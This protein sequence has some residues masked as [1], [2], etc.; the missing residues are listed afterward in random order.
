MFS[1]IDNGKACRQNAA[2]R[3]PG[4]SGDPPGAGDRTVP[5]PGASRSFFLFG[6]LLSV[7][8]T[9]IL[10]LFLI[11]TMSDARA[12]DNI[13]RQG[14][15]VVTGFSGIRP[16]DAPLP[17][18]AS[19]LD[20][21]FINTE[22]T[23]AQI[24]SLA[25]PGAV[26]SG[27]LISAP[28]VLQVKANEVGQVFATVLDDGMGADVPNIYLGQTAAYGLYIV[29]PDD[30]ADG[31]AERTKT[32][33]PDA[34]WM[35]GQFGMATGGGPGSIYKID[36]ATGELSLF[37][38]IPGN[39]G[40]GIG[41]IVFDA[42]NSQFFASDLDTGLIYRLNSTGGV[43]DSFDHGVDG[44]PVRGLAAVSDDGTT[45]DIE[46]PAFD[47]EDPDTWA[48][49]QEERRVHGLAVHNGRLYYAV[50]GQVWS[51][52]VTEDGFAADARWELDADALEGNGPISDMLFDGQGRIYLAER[53]EQRGSYDYSVFAEAEN[54][55]VVRYRLEDPDDPL[56]ESIWVLE[57][58]EYAVGMP[59]DHRQAEGGIALGYSYDETGMMRFG[60]CG[61]MLWSSGHRLRRSVQAEEDAG[62]ADIHGLQG[63]DV[64]LV[65]PDNAPPD[66]SY[67]T[68][69][70][71]FFGDAANSGHMGD[72][73]IWQPCEGEPDFASVP[74][75][76]ELPP[77]IL[78]PGEIPPELPPEFPPGGDF[79]NNLALDKQALPKFCFP[80]AGG[81]LCQYHV[82]VTNTGPDFYFGPVLVEDWLPANPA[83]SA[84]GFAPTPPWSCWN[85][86]ASAYKCFRPGVFLAPG[87][88]IGLDV[89]AWVPESYG[90]CNLRNAA[91]I[92]WAPG[93]TPWNTDPFD[94]FD[95]ANA[96]I[97][98][99]ECEDP[100]EET[101]LEI[102]KSTFETC[103]I[104]GGL[105]NCAYYVS[106][107]NQGPGSYNGNIVVND[108]IPAGTNA[109]FFGAGWAC[110][111]ASPNYTCTFAGANL[112]APGD[113]E[114]FWV[115]VTLPPAQARAMDCRVPNT[116]N[117]TQAPGG[118]PMNTDPTN[119]TA[120][121]DGMVPEE[122]C[123]DE[124]EKTD[125]RI[126]KR[127]YSCY[128][129]DDGLRCY[130]R[131]YVLNM[132]PGAYEGDIKIVDTVP[133]GTTA[134]L[135]GPGWFCGGA[136]P[137]Y[138][139]IYPDAN[140]PNVWDNVFLNVRVDFTREQA[141][142]MDCRIPNTVKITEAAG[143]TPQNLNPA[144]DTDG[145]VGLVPVELCKRPAETNLRIEKK[146]NPTFCSEGQNG[147]WCRYAIRVI[148]EGPGV[149]NGPLEVEEA[150]PAEPVSAIWN[151]PWNCAGI[152]GGGG[153][154]C[155]HP[156]TV[157]PVSASRILFLSVLFSEEDVKAKDCALPNVAKIKV[158]PGG[159]QK[160]TNP[161]DDIAG[162]SA[163]VPARI[164][165][166]DETNLL[167]RKA[168]AQPECNPMGDGK[169]RCPYNVIVRNV[170]Q[171]VY[172]GEI[173]VKDSLPDAAAGATMQ[174]PAPWICVGASPSIL[175]KHP[176]TQLDPGQQVVM[177][178]NVLI[179]PADYDE[180]SLTNK[181]RIV[182]AAGGTTQ[183]QNAG[184]DEGSASLDFPPMIVGDQAFCH[185]PV[186]ATEPECPPGFEWNGERCARPGGLKPPPP[187]Q[188]PVRDCPA[189]YTGTYPDC[190]PR[191]K[192]DPQPETCPRGY[193][194]TPPNCRRIVRP[195]PKPECSGG[196]VYRNG[197]C[198]CRRPLQWNGRRC[199]RPQPQCSGGRV[200]RNGE[201][202]CRRPLQW[203]GR[204]CVRP[205][206]QCSGG[207]VLRRGEC[208]CPGRLRWN[209][210]RCVRP[211]P[212]CSGGRVFR[213][214]ECVCPRRLQWNGQRCVRPRP[215][216]SGGRV[217][218]NGECVCPRGS[219][220]NGQRCTKRQIRRPER[221]NPQPRVN[222]DVLRRNIPQILRNQ[223]NRN[224]QLR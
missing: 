64:S 221:S 187:P 197:R 110:G 177:P 147:W 98:S 2:F 107:V 10:I 120:T 71:G 80:W 195:D 12:Q 19:P 189:G 46:N 57:A 188:P 68:D 94:D 13:L 192:P 34:Q 202:V 16:A 129:V 131:I 69:Y 216:C 148:N 38:S 171:G 74:P 93:G 143:G 9:F 27:Q 211:R 28:P 84:M 112:P 61:G 134:S 160:N 86:G 196:R 163:K 105:V 66:Q 181:A 168:G 70:D 7:F 205:R 56:T 85:T 55:K 119:D 183:N 26:P 213:R 75:Y 48:F 82:R 4:C 73:E 54:S 90:K 144:N 145:A 14:D 52:G 23:S 175:C 122:L 219:R 224:D 91:F 53:G 123:T 15:A 142:Q 172:D 182:E 63:N 40:A 29:L 118:S 100:V 124:P 222:P 140:L 30:D 95:T 116:A 41:D 173:T 185:T 5:P 106:V 164:C 32:G 126:H 31:W 151:L 104:S 24:L 180:C 215:Q 158:A 190:T 87:G 198:V 174:V 89:Y 96:L 137:N 217:Y 193:T 33:A 154:I 141:R 11:A 17:E 72:V 153:A 97:P 115:K 199:V 58:E 109:S 59:P 51:I 127:A 102:F 37:A 22:G 204:R 76:G 139:C 36:G 186:P 60:A 176:S 133:A 156:N 136:S 138:T 223:Q 203:N 155:K 83:G 165:E 162:D 209:G 207:R 25:V 35:A 49:T 113:S 50:A 6:S 166:K 210:Q 200:F 167:L 42:A 88:S 65:R 130:Y 214:G 77:G 178:V 121:A 44:R 101:D 184:D 45:I 67:F 132:G 212:Q 3:D 99:E 78:P 157:I 169:Y 179:P 21:F 146:A 62:D 152:G 220:W 8:S 39:S 149:Y 206:P 208:V 170:G 111:G 191:P 201:C 103:W 1:S 161:D 79:E 135:N 125:L 114:G 18:G 117:I 159:T 128:R 194:G 108:T 43:I 92:E 20:E 81:W 150:L 47:T 218:S